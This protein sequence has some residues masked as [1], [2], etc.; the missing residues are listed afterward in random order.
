MSTGN[1]VK[2]PAKAGSGPGGKTLSGPPARAN[3]LK[4][5]TLSKKD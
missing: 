3:R 1:T 5:F 4:N 2:G